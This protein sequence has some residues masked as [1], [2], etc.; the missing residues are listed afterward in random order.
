[1]PKSFADQFSTAR[2]EARMT[3]E[4]VCEATGASL[5][6]VKYWESGEIEPRPMT[7]RAVLDTLRRRK[8][9]VPA[10]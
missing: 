3:Q 6:T 5:R 9:R 7:Q 2:A 8:K 4:Q 10:K 1:M